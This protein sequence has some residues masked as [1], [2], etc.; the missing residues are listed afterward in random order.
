MKIR[1][2][3]ISTLPYGYGI[4]KVDAVYKPVM[5]VHKEREKQNEEK[6]ANLLKQKT[7][8]EV[9]RHVQAEQEQQ[10]EQKNA[11]QKKLKR[12]EF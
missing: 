10:P 4:K 9:L 8:I 12:R 1:P 6:R 5:D 2:K 3:N 11:Q 7:F